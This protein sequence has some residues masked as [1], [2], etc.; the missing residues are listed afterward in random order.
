MSDWIDWYGG[1]CPVQEETLVDVKYRNGEMRTCVKAMNW[2]ESAPRATAWEH[3]SVPFDIIAYRIA[4][5][6]KKVSESKL[7]V[8]YDQA[9]IWED[10][11]CLAKLSIDDSCV[12]VAINGLHTLSSWRELSA[13]IEATIAEMLA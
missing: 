4:E 12:N 10:D 7:T 6:E 1:E 13:K 11:L 5:E 3:K 9:S 2:R 8:V